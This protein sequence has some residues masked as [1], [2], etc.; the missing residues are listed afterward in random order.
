MKNFCLWLCLVFGL[1]VTAVQ[2][3]TVTGKVTDV[4]T[5]EALE[6]ATVFIEG[7]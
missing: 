6:G 5:G 1:G 2:A 3:Q 7:G 4:E